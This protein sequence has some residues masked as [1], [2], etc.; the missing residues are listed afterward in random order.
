MN[1][2]RYSPKGS[3]QLVV[4]NRFYDVAYQSMYAN[5]IGE[6]SSV[7]NE[8]GFYIGLETNI[9]R[10]FKLNTYGDLFYFPWKKYQVSKNGTH[11]FDGVF[12]LSFSPR[13]ELDMFIRYRYKNK[14]KDFTPEE[15]EK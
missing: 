2:L 6:G 7:Q 3:F 10:Y 8:S 15:G 11:G 1:M 9:L 12:Q 4:M 5:S 13:Y 14:Y